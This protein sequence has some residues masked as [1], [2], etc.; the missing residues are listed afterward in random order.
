MGIRFPVLGS[1]GYKYVENPVGMLTG[2]NASSPAKLGESAPAAVEKSTSKLG[3]VKRW[4]SPLALLTRKDDEEDGVKE[5]VVTADNYLGFGMANPIGDSGFNS[6]ATTAHHSTAPH[7]AA[8]VHAAL[9]AAQPISRRPRELNTRKTRGDG[10]LQSSNAGPPQL[11]RI[12][13]RTATPIT[14][15]IKVDARIQKMVYDAVHENCPEA[16]NAME[17]FQ[18]CLEVYDEDNNHDSMVYHLDESFLCSQVGVAGDDWL[19]RYKALITLQDLE[20]EGL[21]DSYYLE[22]FKQQMIPANEQQLIGAHYLGAILHTLVCTKIISS[23]QMRTIAT[24]ALTSEDFRKGTI[25][26]DGFI[27]PPSQSIFNRLPLRDGPNRILALA[28]LIQAS[29]YEATKCFGGVWDN[30]FH[31]DAAHQLQKYY[32][33]YYFTLNNPQK[34]LPPSMQEY[35]RTW[36]RNEGRMLQRAAVLNNFLSDLEADPDS[37]DYAFYSIIRATYFPIPSQLGR[38]GFEYMTKCLYGRANDTG[39]PHHEIPI[40]LSLL[41]QFD[42][43][44]GYDVEEEKWIK[45]QIARDFKAFEEHEAE[46]KKDVKQKQADLKAFLKSN[47]LH[48]IDQLLNQIKSTEEMDELSSRGLLPTMDHMAAHRAHFQVGK[49]KHS[50][51]THAS[52]ANTRVDTKFQYMFNR[53]KNAFRKPAARVESGKPF[54]ATKYRKSTP[55]L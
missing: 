18:F 32:E 20:K 16:I 12:V 34:S 46:L 38:L 43:I 4:A 39:I 6:Q 41:P 3:L 15:P 44:L 54:D 23:G 49:F 50:P 33:A 19:A 52:M 14:D 36:C 35:S 8:A 48:D 1:G 27:Q 26:R 29:V 42:M 45:D 17:S 13:T 28:S 31:A 40:M 30:V 55:L 21:L 25:P 11:A 5:V 9:V 37:F 22:L 53:V 47:R 7:S 24:L 51:H 2:R 10:N